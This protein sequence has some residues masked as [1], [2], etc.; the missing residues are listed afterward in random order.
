MIQGFQ[1]DVGVLRS[2]SANAANINED[3]ATS[4]AQAV[5]ATDIVINRHPGWLAVS[6]LSACAAVCRQQFAVIQTDVDQISTKLLFNANT[7]EQTEADVT[8]K[9]NAIIQQ[10]N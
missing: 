8:Q 7:Y 9:I 5:S 2:A 4:D 3:Y 1:V 6:T 10:L